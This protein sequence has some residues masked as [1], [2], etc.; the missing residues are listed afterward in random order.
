MTERSVGVLLPPEFPPEG[1]RDAARRTERAG[2]D[3]LWLFESCFWTGGIATSAVAL[4]ATER[5]MVGL[6]II[7]AL[8][9]N[10]AMTAMEF[11]T[12]VPAGSCP[13]SVTACRNGCGRS[14]PP[15]RRSWRPLRKP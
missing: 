8:Y 1:L 3:S 9:P 5:I 6:G 7:A 13:A 15:R 4:A 11:A 2:F 12:L 14:A 10:P